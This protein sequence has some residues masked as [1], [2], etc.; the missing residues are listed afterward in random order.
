M[1]AAIRRSLAPGLFL[2][3]R[4]TAPARLEPDFLVIG[5]AKA[6][7]SSLYYY[8]IEHPN[9]APARR[10][11]VHY[12]D[13]NF[14]RGRDWYRAHFPLR[15]YRS[16][17]RRVR[18][19]E[20]IVGEATPYYMFHPTSP[21]RIAAALPKVKVIVL[22]RNPIDRAYSQF[23]HEYRNRRETLDFEDALAAEE[24][25]L[26]GEAERLRREPAYQSVAWQRHS[27]LARG[28]YAEQLE[29]WRERIPA[30]RMLVLSAEE[31]L[32]HTGELFGQVTRF[33]GIPEYQLPEYP[34]HNA[35]RYDPMSPQ[36]RAEL[37]EYF[38]PHNA[39]L[40][41]LLGRDFGWDR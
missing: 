41:D 29:V 8:L 5:A 19:R 16:F 33:L 30:E 4:L 28:R 18:G 10:E 23:T 13:L 11:E 39:R 35:F 3:R 22:L 14:T 38:R 37:V 26:A 27:Y 34:R 15:A 17:E 12:Y 25:R 32:E 20:I 36:T 40:Y 9:V 1:R 31:F 24:E 21:D 7:T 6:G 2:V